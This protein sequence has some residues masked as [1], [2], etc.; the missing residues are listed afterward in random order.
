MLWIYQEY[1]I[2]AIILLAYSLY[3]YWSNSR[4][5]SQNQ[6]KLAFQSYFDVQTKV[7]INEGPSIEE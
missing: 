7:L 4:D 3:T 6:E 1:Y 5:I 2:F